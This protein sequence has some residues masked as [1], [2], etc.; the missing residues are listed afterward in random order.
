MLSS[1]RNAS[2]GS[3]PVDDEREAL[4]G[5]TRPR[6]EATAPIAGDGVR[7]KEVRC[8]VVWCTHSA[9]RRQQFHVAPGV[10]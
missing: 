5:D 4:A 9:A 2:F 8:M 3:L 7:Y 10:G 6:T 1:L